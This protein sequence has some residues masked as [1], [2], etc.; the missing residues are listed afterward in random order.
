MTAAVEIYTIEE[1]DRRLSEA[2]ELELTN[3]SRT[4]RWKLAKE[5]R[6]PPKGAIGPWLSDVLLY[7]ADPDDY[8]YNGESA[9]SSDAEKP[10]VKVR[11]VRRRAV[12]RA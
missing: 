1:P 5:G 8:R 9:V 7:C 2:E 12:R 10:D 11:K 4:T 3:Q 6:Y